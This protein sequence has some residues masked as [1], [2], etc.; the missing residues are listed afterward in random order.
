MQYIGYKIADIY[1]QILVDRDT[2][3]QIIMYEIELEMIMFTS[4]TTRR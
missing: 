1:T 2:E 3:T 4:K